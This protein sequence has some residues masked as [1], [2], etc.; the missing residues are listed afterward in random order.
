MGFQ[1][2]EYYRDDSGPS[3]F[4]TGPR[5][6]VTNLVIVNAAV[7]LL[8]LFL[9][10][11]HGRDHWLA[12][13]LAVS[14]DVLGKPWLW[15]K[16]V[17]YGFVHD[18]LS[19]GHLFWNMFG[20]WIFGRDVEL[21]YGRKELL[22]IYLT[23]LVLG[24][25]VWCLREQ[26]FT[27]REGFVQLIGASGAVTAVV[28]LFVFHY[29]TRTILLMFVIPVPAWVLGILII[30]GNMLFLLAEETSRH[31]VAFDV[32]LVGAAFAIA[33]F[34]LGWNL[35]RIV[36]DFRRF[37]ERRTGPKPGPNLRIHN[38]ESH[39]EAL[40]DKADRILEKVS[41]EGMDSLTSKERRILEDYSR[42][43][44]RKHN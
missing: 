17:T 24:S 5:M 25:L 38:T 6:M 4:R 32:H 26:L 9:A 22:R 15:W 1:D 35:G 20:L 28:L 40:D 36:P 29:P 2:R 41:R 42:R 12:D 11:D 39:D 19:I 37:R 14:P 13:L 33:Y 21:I 43:M 27:Q 34:R 18:P 7:F 31:Q 44:R 16:L 8:D 23:A 3:G 10:K 30:G